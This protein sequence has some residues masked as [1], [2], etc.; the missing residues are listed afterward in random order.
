M[1]S[2]HF[3]KKLFVE[4]VIIPTDPIISKDGIKKRK[5]FK[6]SFLSKVS[7]KEKKLISIVVIDRPLLTYCQAW[8]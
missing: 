8:H 2:K 3:L 5:P 1:R 4:Q 6:L 7:L